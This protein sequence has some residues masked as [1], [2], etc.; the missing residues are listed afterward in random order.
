ML[1]GMTRVATFAVCSSLVISAISSAESVLLDLPTGQNNTTN[2][3]W[4]SSPSLMNGFDISS[5]HMNFQDLGYWATPGNLFAYDFGSDSSQIGRITIT[6]HES[7]LVGL[8]GL[9]LSGWGA[10]DAFAILR[11]FNDGELLFD[12][13]F[14]LYGQSDFRNLEFDGIFGS[15][16]VIELEN[17]LNVGVGMDNIEIDVVP[18]PGALALLGLAGV[19]GNR[20]RRR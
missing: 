20:R 11:V 12:N 3:E 9:D 5:E 4:T 13:L 14:E 6:A 7:N 8:E 19:A 16:I 1:P 15:E 10:E 2:F 17:V 18:A